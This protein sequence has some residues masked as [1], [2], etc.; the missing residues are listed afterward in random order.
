MDAPVD[1]GLSSSLS[2][3]CQGD[4]SRSGLSGLELA[5]AFFQALFLGD[6]AVDEDDR[7]R[8]AVVVG[9]RDDDRLADSLHTVAPAEPHIS[10]PA[11]RLAHLLE[12]PSRRRLALP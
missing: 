6:V 10:G 8:S 11:P 5:E 2:P 3:A 12:H 4:P 1:K 7:D 9:V